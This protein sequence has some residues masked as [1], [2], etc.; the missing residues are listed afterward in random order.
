MYTAK[1][2]I[3]AATADEVCEVLSQSKR[4]K[5]VAGNM[6]LRLSRG[7]YNKLIDIT[8]LQ[9]DY[10]KITANQIHIGACTTLRAIEKSAIIREAFG[11]A[12]ADILRHI[13]GVQFRNTATIGG[14]IFLKHGFSDIITL[15]LALDADLIFHNSGWMKLSEYLKKQIKGDLLKEI[16]I[17]LPQ[18]IAFK[19]YKHTA[20]DLSL[21]NAAAVQKENTVRIALGSRPAA[22]EARE[23]TAE[24]KIKDIAEA[25]CYG[26][27]MRASAE[28]RKAIAE[29]LISECMKALDKK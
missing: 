21:L 11:N 6:W 25:F 18:N 2:Y 10:I 29:N 20:T 4:N 9:L 12:F 22:A 16:V 28:Y 1:E 8:N 3:K 15:L 24:T 14:N 7:N 17:G 19:S 26:S 5:I 27:N 13:V 23:F